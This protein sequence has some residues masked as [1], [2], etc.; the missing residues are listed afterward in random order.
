LVGFGS[1][2]SLQGSLCFCGGC[3]Y[4]WSIVGDG[5]E[6]MARNDDYASNA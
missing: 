2:L 5:S 3:S 1:G 6:K 4:S